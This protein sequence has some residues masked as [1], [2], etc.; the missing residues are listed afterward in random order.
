MNSKKIDKLISASY[1]ENDLDQKTVNKIAS[2][3]GRAD[4]KKYINGLKLVENKKSL[5]ISSPA[6]NQDLKSFEKLFPHKKI[7]LRKDPSLMLGVRVVDND[8]VYEFTLRNS[9]DKIL[10]YIEQNYD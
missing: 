2:L 9:L 6:N 8:L 7:V 5:I 10:N 4:L 3:I 1:K